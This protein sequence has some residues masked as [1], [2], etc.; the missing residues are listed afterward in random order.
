MKTSAYSGATIRKKEFLFHGLFWLLFTYFT[1]VQL[2]FQQPE[3]LTIKKLSVF[4]ISGGIIFIVT[5]YFNYLLVLPQVFERINWKRIVIGAITV[6]IFFITLRYLLEEILINLF[7]GHGNYFEGTSVIYYVYD[8][9][10]YGSFSIIISSILWIL[11]F[12]MRLLEY[13]NHILEEKRSTEVKFLKAQLNP[14]FLFNTLNNIYSLVYFK[15]DKS[16][17]AIEK[18]S[19]LMRYTTYETTKK[20]ISLQQE[21]DY[22]KA[23]VELNQLRHESKNIIDFIVAIENPLTQ[24]PPFLLS[25]LIENALKHGAYTENRPILF[26]LRQTKNKLSLKVVNR[27]SQTKKDKLGGIGLDNLRKNLEINYPGAHS[28]NVVNERE[29]F[30]AQ[31]EIKLNGKQD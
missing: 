6:Y 14:Q 20:R 19:E 2:D 3:I 11:F 31:L 16:L 23:Y 27:I 18:L 28:L 1:L 29:T 9:L 15:S 21:V 26:D 13:N 5:F 4:E 24:I 25:P 10:Y 22:I 8:N 12:N 30:S 17:P 7:I